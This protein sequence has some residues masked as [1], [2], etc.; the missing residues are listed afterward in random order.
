MFS[1]HSQDLQ[2]LQVKFARKYN[3]D[4]L[5]ISRGHGTTKTLSTVKN[6]IQINLRQ[7]QEIT[8]AADGKTATLGGGVYNDNVVNALH[9]KG[10]SSGMFNDNDPCT[11]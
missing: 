1:R 10:K 2:R 5:A 4:F 3:I 11:M 7:L 6:G 8:V 9:A